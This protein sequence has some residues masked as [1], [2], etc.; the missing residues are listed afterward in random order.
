[1][2]ARD[3]T[4]GIDYVRE[5]HAGTAENIVFKSH[6]II[7][8]DIVLHLDVV[9]DYNF[10]TDKNTLTERT[11]LTDPGSG[12]DMN[13]MPDSCS[14]ANLGAIVDDGGRMSSVIHDQ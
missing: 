12:G 8:R 9:A 10:I 7:D 6:F 14:W 5:D 13:P 1:M 3:V 2:F 4:A 11:A